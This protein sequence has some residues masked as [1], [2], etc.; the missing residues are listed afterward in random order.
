MIAMKRTLLSLLILL[1]LV[2]WVVPIARA[3]EMALSQTVQASQ[4]AVYQIDLHNETAITHDY[5]L[6]LS[7]LPATLTT[8]FTQGGPLVTQIAVSANAYGLV[9]IQVAVPAETAVGHYTAQFSATRDDGSTLTLPVTLNV[10]NVYAVKIISQNL[11][12]TAFSGQS[13]TFA[14]TAANSGAAAVTN[15]ALAVDVPAKWIVQTDP[16]T[17]PSLE[18]GAEAAFNVTVLVPASQVSKDQEL[19]LALTSDQ[20]TSPDSSLM[21]RVQKSPTFLYVATAVM[22][23][24][25]LGVFVY[26]RRKGRR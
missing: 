22:G 24:A 19:K 26:F 2:G 12:L 6:T 9:T 23:L 3:D 7:G 18:P 10:E 16:V 25:I 21:V 5:T 1:A 4:T 13:F 15:L 8:T 14:A 17:L 20:T 11:N